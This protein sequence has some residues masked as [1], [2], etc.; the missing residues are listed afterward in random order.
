MQ[1]V[2]PRYLSI[3]NLGRFVTSITQ[4][5]PPWCFLFGTFILAS[6]EKYG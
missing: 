3:T 1:Q 2:N 6:G 4:T 5:Y